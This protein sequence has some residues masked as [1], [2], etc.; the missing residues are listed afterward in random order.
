MFK[1][2]SFP[3]STFATQQSSNKVKNFIVMISTRNSGNIDMLAS[4]RSPFI[5]E[6]FTILLI[7]KYAQMSILSNV[8]NK[9]A[10]HTSCVLA[11]EKKYFAFI[12]IELV[13]LELF[14]KSAIQNLL[15]F[16]SN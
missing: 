6:R 12:S 2:I 16:L 5:D 9:L 4:Q 3:L 14:F 7:Q 8:N 15:G 13:F 1:I 11:S 10:S